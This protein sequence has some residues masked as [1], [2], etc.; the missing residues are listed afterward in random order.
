MISIL[1]GTNG[2]KEALRALDRLRSD[3]RERAMVAALN[4]TADKARVEMRRAITDEFDLKARDVTPRLAV[5]GASFKGKVNL[6]A[7]LEAL[8]GSKRGRSMNVIKFL[9]RPVSLA[10]A[11]KGKQ[12]GFRFKRGGPI[13]QIPGAFVGNDGRTVFIREAGAGRLPIRAVQVIDVQQMFNT[14]RINSR[15]VRR[16]ETEWLIEFERAAKNL[17]ERFNSA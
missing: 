14:R 2:I 4:K 5:R 3:L 12:L 9:R 1:V 7:I 15:V 13:K 17:I 8:P 6:T 11:R 16:I 10:Q